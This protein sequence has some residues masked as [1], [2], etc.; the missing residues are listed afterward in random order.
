MGYLELGYLKLPATLYIKL[1]VI[2]L[3]PNQP[4]LSQT[5]IA[6]TIDQE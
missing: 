5:L 2:S 6:K 1:F 3:G 4:Q